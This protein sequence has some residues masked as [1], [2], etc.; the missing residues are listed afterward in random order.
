MCARV[1]GNVEHRELDAERREAHLVA[2]ADRMRESGD[3]LVARPI[4]GN[5]VA[6]QQLGDAADVVGV[7]VGGED[8]GELEL[9][10]REIV[11]HRLRLA[12]IDHRGMARVAQRPDIV[13]LERFDWNDLEHGPAVLCAER[14]AEV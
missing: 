13:V 10:A 5:A 1:P 2:A 3:R 12:G 7:V 14:R 6:L 11:E 9:L 4:D 8:R